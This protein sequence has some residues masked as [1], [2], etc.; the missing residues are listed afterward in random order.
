LKGK[1]HFDVRVL[2]LGFLPGNLADI[3]KKKKK[4]KGRTTKGVVGLAIAPQKKKK[5]MSKAWLYATWFPRGIPKAMMNEIG[6]AAQA[7]AHPEALARVALLE[8]QGK[9]PYKVARAEFVQMYLAS[10]PYR[11]RA[12]IAEWEVLKVKVFSRKVDLQDF[13]DLMYLLAWAYLFYTIGEMFGRGSLYGY[14]F[15]GEIHRQE[16]HNAIVFKEKEAKDMEA[17]VQRLEK[18]TADWLK[19]MEEAN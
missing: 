3:Q 17:V 2:R 13:V 7:I 18:E 4:G 19:S 5:K 10:W 9:N 15:D 12:S 14:S 11:L 16:A 6:G 8:S 1:R